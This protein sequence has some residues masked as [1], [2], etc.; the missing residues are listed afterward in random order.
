MRTTVTFVIILLTLGFS[1]CNS[2]NGDSEESIGT[3]KNIY[4]IEIEDNKK[5][6]VVEDMMVHI[7]NMSDD[8][9]STANAETL[10]FE[11]LEESL[12][13]NIGLLTSNCTMTGKAHDE[14]HKWL[15]PF[16]GL[17]DELNKA[18]NYDDKQIV[19]QSLEE[20]ML[21]FDAYF[22]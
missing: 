12:E 14:L 21:E 9:K 4:N 19:F 2:A 22:E 11:G 16:I 13:G 15:V 17:V 10:D 18:E 8:I 1:S 5:W 6:V 20:S 7:Q 3:A